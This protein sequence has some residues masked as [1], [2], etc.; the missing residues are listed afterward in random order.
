LSYESA[1]N[2]SFLERL[3][4]PLRRQRV[5]LKPP[6]VC[7]QLMLGTEYGGYAVCPTG[8]GPEAVVYSFGV[9]CDVSFD[10][11]L[12][13]ARGVA[14]HAFDPTPRS[15]D[16]LKTQT[17]PESFVFHPWGIADFDGTARFHAPK[18][19]TH[20]SHT[21]LD[22]G[23]VGTGTVEV[24]VFRLRTIM[25]KLGHDRIDILKMDIEGAEYGVLGD[26]L[27]SGTPIAQI[28]IE[29]HHGRSGVPLSKTQAAVD[30]LELAGFRVFHASPSGYE[31][32]FLR[33]T[34]P[35]SADT[36]SSGV[37]PE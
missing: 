21:L 29:F 35:P 24:P 12:I 15:I 33:T 22:G 34:Q 28:L 2:M 8:L 23:D 3:L 11:G 4:R 17:L 26:V 25:D 31:F 7:E 30:A 1:C 14:V 32:S 5:Q 9:G 37:S 10:Q 19:P 16:W 27:G 13:A 20:V 36:V 6:I 18:D